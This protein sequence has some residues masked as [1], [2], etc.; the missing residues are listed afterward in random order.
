[1]TSNSSVRKKVQT[2]LLLGPRTTSNVKVTL[3]E[4]VSVTLNK[5]FRLSKQTGL[6][7]TFENG[8]RRDILF[9]ILP[10][11]GQ[12]SPRLMNLPM[13]CVK[14]WQNTAQNTILLKL[15]RRKTLELKL[16]I[17]LPQILPQQSQAP[18]FK[19]E[20]PKK[21]KSLLSGLNGGNV[22]ANIR[23]ARY[24]NTPMKTM[25]SVTRGNIFLASMTA[26]FF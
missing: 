7:R 13:P 2:R 17:E 16:T 6:L 14:T 20:L 12:P 25:I 1:M 23:L 21:K 18:D 15:L 11:S 22:A 8:G 4:C 19:E 5:N 10:V 26:T 9:R 3:V 24:V